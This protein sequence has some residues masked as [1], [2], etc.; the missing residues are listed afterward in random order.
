MLKKI[1]I[2][3]FVL[4]IAAH[5]YAES[6]WVLIAA[7]DDNINIWEGRKKSQE[8]TTTK[9][10]IKISVFSGRIFNKKEKSYTFQKW[11]VSHEDCIAGYGK[12]VSL[13][14][15]GKY[16]HENDFV[17]NGGNVASAVAEIACYPVLEEKKNRD[18][19]SI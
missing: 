1:F 10:G 17:I 7:S 5:A 14:I 15:Q 18:S 16:Q 8:D 12:V 2:T 9:G 3:F 11:Y 13:D 6:D 19:K 4:C